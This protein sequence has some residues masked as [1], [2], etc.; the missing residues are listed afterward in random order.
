MLSK[1]QI[2]EIQSL[3]LKKFRDAAKLFIAEGKK[4]I[5]EIIAHQPNLIKELFATD[6]F[7]RLH[8][9]KLKSSN[10]GF[11]TVTDTELKKISLQATPNEALALCFHLPASENKIDFKSQF[12]LYLDDIRD[13]GNL[14][15][16]IRLAD[17]FGLQTVFCSPG[18]C[19]LYNPKVIQS[20]MGSF[21]RV[22]LKYIELQDVI[23]NYKI[24]TIYGGVLNGKN[25]FIVKSFIQDSS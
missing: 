1:N 23:S 9:E 20:T 18:T 19:E 8:K 13:P 16:I 5:L 3:Q 21:L 2:K 4:T 10:V 11:T 15:T 17:W 7:L 25:L 24:E 14:G 12:A 6:E 22:T